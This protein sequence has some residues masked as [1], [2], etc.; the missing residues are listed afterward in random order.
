MFADRSFLAKRLTIMIIDRYDPVNLFEMVPKLS[1]D[2]DAELSQL[3]SILD[4]DVL[5][6]QVRADLVR[7][8]PNATTHGRHSTPVEV[9]LRLLVVKRLC[10]WSYEE[11]EDF[12]P[13]SLVLRQFCRIYLESAPDDTTL[14][15]WTNL[16]GPGT[17]EQLDERVVELARSLKVTRGWKLRV[18]STAAET[19]I[20]HPTDSGILGDGVWV[21]NRLLYRAKEVVGEGTEL[22][23]ELFRSRTLTA[24]RV[25]QQLLRLVRHKGEEAAEE[26]KAI[27][28]KLIDMALESRAQT[29]R[30]RVGLQERGGLVAK[31]LVERFAHFLPLVD[32]AI[33]R[34]TQQGLK[35]ASVPAKE[36]L[37]GL[38]EPHTQ[39]IQRHEAGKVVEFDRKLWIEEEEGGIVSGYRLA[40][41]GGQDYP[42]LAGSLRDHKRRF[43]RPPRVL[44]R[45]RGAYTPSNEVLAE[46]EGVAPVVIHFAGKVALGTASSESDEEP[47]VTFLDG[48]GNEVASA[49]VSCNQNRKKSKFT[50]TAPHDNIT[51]RF[52]SAD[53]AR[54]ADVSISDISLH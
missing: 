27:C 43:G 37:L 51:V 12:I 47:R 8:Y 45:D 9:I 23:K 17:I 25:A 11:T 34:A 22:G 21:L 14:I 10:D 15:R 40:E 6:Q 35:G 39:V 46:R 5:F 20:H 30:V 3:D 13:D 36:K 49:D 50:F 28:A 44:A 19:N 18:G 7:R 16:I 2:M 52:S 1:L 4:D 24:R 32:Q 42:Y 54:P 38:F 31:R 53:P 41:G 26:M 33:L 29:E 48:S